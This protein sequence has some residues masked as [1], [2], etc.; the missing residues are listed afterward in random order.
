MSEKGPC[1]VCGGRI[2]PD[3][4]NSVCERC[5]L[6]AGLRGGEEEIRAEVLQ[7]R[8][9]TERVAYVREVCSDNPSLRDRLLAW[10][11]E[12]KTPNL[13][14]ASETGP[15][16][17]LVNGRYQLLQVIG[18]G[19]FGRVYLAAQLVP[20]ERRVAVK[21]LKLGMDTRQVVARFDLERQ[22]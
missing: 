4:S 12:S 7:I 14:A 6:Q 8:S 9:P 19:G 13:P 20:V 17:P 21:V 15:D 10:L 2:A 5:Q 11:T 3:S 22:A 1:A 18:E 16:L